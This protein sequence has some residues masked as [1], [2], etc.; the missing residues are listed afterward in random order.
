MPELAQPNA[1][2]MPRELLDNVVHHVTPDRPGRT[3]RIV[4]RDQ[5]S[6][7][8]AEIR[9][10][11]G[12]SLI[13]K[14]ARYDWAEPRFRTSRI[15]SRLLVENTAVEAPAPLE[16]PADLAEKP[17]EAYWRIDHPTLDELWERLDRTE[18]LDVLRSWG[19]LTARVHAVKLSGFGMLSDPGTNQRTIGEYL[20]QE[21]HDRLLPAVWGEW[22]DAIPLVERLLEAV[23]EVEA[24]VGG[25]SRLVHND[26]HMGNVL[27]TTRD[28]PVRCVGL[29]DLETA[30]AAPPEA[31]LAVVEVH[32]GPHLSQP[33][34]GNWSAHF[35]AGY[36]QRVDGWVVNFYRAFHLLNMGFYSALVGHDWHAAE[37]G[38]AASSE[39]DRLF[40]RRLV[41][42]RSEN[43]AERPDTGYLAAEARGAG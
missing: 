12:R 15:A 7:D 27:C 9:L 33:I 23:P 40:D 11:D 16:V 29:I 3:E 10:E 24:R 20:T 32:H 8:F 4:H 2:R 13:V 42:V 6:N 1:S 37:V 21:L 26:L 22:P 19:E 18:R 35:R 28:G 5:H 25:S 31:D 14:R 38:S 36:G 39:I 17:V 34:R 30:L 41:A 43:G